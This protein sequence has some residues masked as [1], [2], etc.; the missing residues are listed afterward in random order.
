MDREDYGEEIT[1]KPTVTEVEVA[2]RKGSAHTIAST[3]HDAFD[4]E[5]YMPPFLSDAIF[6]GHLVTDMDS[7]AG[8]IGAAELYGALNLTISPSFPSPPRPF[9]LSFDVF[10]PSPFSFFPFTNSGGIAARA[11][12]VNSETAFC[13]EYWGLEAPPPVEEQ[14]ERYPNAGVCLVD[15]QQMSQLN[16]SIDLERI[17][18]VIDHHALQVHQPSVFFYLQHVTGHLAPSDL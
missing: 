14:L 9:H 4:V 2:K 15:H 10:Y 18:G 13:L 1:R 12:E 7:I 8:S 3:L 16:K 17:V 11:S 5:T 6:V